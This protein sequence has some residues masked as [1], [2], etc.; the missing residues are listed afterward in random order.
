M[1]SMAIDFSDRLLKPNRYPNTCKFRRFHAFFIHFQS[2]Y[3]L[4][5][6]HDHEQV[7]LQNM[8][9]FSDFRSLQ[10]IRRNI[11]KKTPKQFVYYTELL[12]LTI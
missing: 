2:T 10:T 8:I 11:L 6:L 9:D 1:K 3:R 5:L 12:S 7:Q 4:N